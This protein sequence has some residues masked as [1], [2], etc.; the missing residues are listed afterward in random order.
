MSAGKSEKRKV[1]SDLATLHR[2]GS[3]YRAIKKEAERRIRK[4]T[5]FAVGERNKTKTMENPKLVLRRFI[6]KVELCG[7]GENPDEAWGN[8][9]EAFSLDPGPP[10]DEWREEELELS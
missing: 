2:D 8:A 3:V 10:P 6:F 5:L 1:S 4:K 7:I 9:V